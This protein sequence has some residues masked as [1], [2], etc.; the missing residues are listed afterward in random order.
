[1][2]PRLAISLFATPVVVF[3][4]PE[5]EGVNAELAA[6]L[7][8]EERRVPSWQRANVGGWHSGPDLAQRQVPAIQTLIRAI[9]DRVGLTVSTLAADAS[10]PDLPRFRYGVTAW[11]MIMRDGH[12]VVPHDH[13]EAHFSVAYYVDAGDDA[14]APSG[15]LAFLD[16]RRGG[17][18]IPGMPTAFD[19]AARTSA[20][21]IFPGW[22]Q[23]HVHAYRGQRP[24]IC[25]SANLAMDPL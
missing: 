5:M 4:L 13:G 2:E 3:D 10:I 9:V 16:P 11:A 18:A 12:Y 22:L 19:V 23:H 24:R 8:D 25:I 14:P 20:L 15:R 1:M 6:L 21:A 7:L 17:R